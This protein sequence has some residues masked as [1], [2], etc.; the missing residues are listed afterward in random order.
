MVYKTECPQNFTG[1][2]QIP[3][4]TSYDFGMKTYYPSMDPKSKGGEYKSRKKAKL[5]VNQSE[6]TNNLLKIMESYDEEK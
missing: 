6:R 5:E 1:N 3:N 4:L 2:K